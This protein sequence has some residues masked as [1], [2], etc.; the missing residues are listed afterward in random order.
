M[1][2]TRRALAPLTLAVLTACAGPVPRATAQQ[3]R[4]PPP[5]RPVDLPPAVPQAQRAGDLGGLLLTGAAGPAGTPLLLSYAFPAGAL[6]RG[7][8]LAARLVQGNRALLLQFQV[9][10]R[11]PDGSARIGMIALEAP[12]LRPNQ[13][14]GVIL[15][16]IPAAGRAL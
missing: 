7:D 8:G 5:R 15:S 9:I 13:H 2:L 3:R 14:A 4:P 10:R 1:K 12:P 6:A 16:R 11:H